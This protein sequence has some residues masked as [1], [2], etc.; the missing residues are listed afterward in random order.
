MRC[1][2]NFPAPVG[3]PIQPEM[4]VASEPESGF[5]PAEGMMD[6][7]SR[8]PAGAE[9]L[10]PAQPHATTAD[11]SQANV[12]PSIPFPA[13]DASSGAVPFAPGMVS[14]ETSGRPLGP[15]SESAPIVA[16]FMAFETPGAKG[17]N[18]SPSPTCTDAELREAQQ[19]EIICQEFSRQTAAGL[20]LTAAARIVG[21]S[22]SWFSGESAPY[23]RWLR[24]GIAALLPRRGDAGARPT[25]FPDLPEWFIPAC[26]FFYRHI[27]RTHEAGSAPEA[28]RRAISMPHAL[29]HRPDLVPKLAAFLGIAP[30]PTR[31]ALATEK[32]ELPACAAEL[33]DAI[34]ARQRAGKSLLPERLMRQIPAPAPII[35]SLRSPRDAWLRYIESPGSLMLTVDEDGI[36]RFLEP[37]EWWTID[38][39]TINFVCTVPLARPGD[40][41]YDKFGVLA[42]RFQFLLV[43]D[44]RSYFITGFSYTARPRSSYRAED[45]NATL[46]T[47]FVEHGRPRQMVLENGISAARIVTDALTQCGVG[48]LR[49]RSPHQKVVENVFGKLW[50]KL[51]LERGQ[52]GR[53][54]GEE[55][56]T[57]NTLVSCRNG[58][59]DPRQHFL[60]LEEVLR[61]LREAIADH[62]ASLIDG[63][64]GRWIPSEYFAQKAKAHLRPL[65]PDSA[66]IFSP[67]IAAGNDGR[68]LLV[69]TACLKTSVQLFPG[70]S[71]SFAFAN[72]TLARWYG[73]RVKLYFNPLAP[74]CVAKIVLAESY[75]GERAGAVIGDALQIDRQARFTRRLLGYGLDPDI[76]LAQTRANALALRRSAQAVRPDRTAAPITE[77]TRTGQDIAPI[78]AAHGRPVENITPLDPPVD[79]AA[80]RREIEEFETRNAH[81]FS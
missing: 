65:A 10:Q 17:S 29:D 35:Q 46:H 78:A 57:T 63:R 34:L 2:L 76:G 25:V 58:H 54:R 12:A 11:A 40:P 13:S 50:T 28:V 56:D 67:V 47:A 70:F 24:D 7:S 52:V 61:A 53:Y 36:E 42:G 64:Y 48:I 41:C 16:G 75:R 26:Q 55:S 23:Q 69:R 38:D 59:T 79:L 3:E 49:A 44:H 33:R 60:P 4:A 37:G 30:T 27:N 14:E 22:P 74:D 31:S 68:G 32:I 39:G 6:A 20:S 18:P 9:N 73:A 43:V 66:W 1:P 15:C 72:E 19:R 62:N 80:R 8:D 77:E 51:S 45:L 71:Q 5:E 21:K 81:L